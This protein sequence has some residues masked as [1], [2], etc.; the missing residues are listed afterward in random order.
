MIAITLRCNE[1]ID[2]YEV[3]VM[4]FIKLGDVDACKMHP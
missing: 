3:I 2:I 1:F 4:L